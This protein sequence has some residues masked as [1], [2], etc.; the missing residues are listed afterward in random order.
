M[1]GCKINWQPAAKV[2]S[3]TTQNDNTT[4]RQPGKKILNVFLPICFCNS[5]LYVIMRLHFYYLLG[6]PGGN[7]RVKVCQQQGPAD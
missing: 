4:K 1:A 6:N 3:V 2:S 7:I 5:F